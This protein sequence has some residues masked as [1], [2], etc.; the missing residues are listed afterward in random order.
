MQFV[1]I[2]PRRSADA[3]SSRY[4]AAS[5]RGA[6]TPKNRRR[7]RARG[8][9]AGKSPCRAFYNTTVSGLARRVMRRRR[10][11]QPLRYEKHNECKSW[12]K[13]QGYHF[14]HEG[15]HARQE[16]S[17]SHRTTAC[18]GM[19]HKPRFS[20][21]L[22]ALLARGAV[23]QIVRQHYSLMELA[24]GVRIIA[25]SNKQ[26]KATVTTGLSEWSDFDPQMRRTTN[27]AREAHRQNTPT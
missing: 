4:T 21:L 6:S 14:P 26:T 12:L 8:L 7:C 13:K 24:G 22:G 9:H 23:Q 15:V 20:L 3:L 27:Q 18:G 25:Y 5:C 19:L 17:A 11:K 2:L 1:K 10:H 16:D